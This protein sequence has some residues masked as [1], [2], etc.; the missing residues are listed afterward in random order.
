MNITRFSVI[1]SPLGPLTV[2]AV[3]KALTGLWFETPHQART[4]RWVQD[5]THPVLQQTQQE[6]AQYFA[7]KRRAFDLVLQPQG[8][9]FQQ[10]VWMQLLKV[11]FGTTSTYGALARA[12]NKPQAARAVGAAVGANPI[13]IIVPC[14][15]IVGQDGSLTGYAWG[16]ERKT[17]LLKLEE[18]SSLN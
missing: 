10:A 12:L 16:L 17:A 5:P 18:Q 3:G 14:H 9:A 4:Q 13:S 11:D 15:R 8:T 2:A 7:G 6:I 1:T